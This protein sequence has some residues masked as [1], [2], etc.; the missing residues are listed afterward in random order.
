MTIELLTIH[1]AYS[2]LLNVLPNVVNNVL[3]YKMI[4]ICNSEPCF[5]TP[6]V[7]ISSRKHKKLCRLILNVK[8]S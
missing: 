4:T 3:G 6:E 1:N 5:V 8:A 2:D 7:K